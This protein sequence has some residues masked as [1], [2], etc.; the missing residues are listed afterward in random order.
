LFD[1]G[2]STTSIIEF[3]I[4]IEVQSLPSLEHN[5]PLSDVVLFLSLFLLRRR[6]I[7]MAMIVAMMRR[8]PIIAIKTIAHK[9]ND[10]LE[11]IYLKLIMNSS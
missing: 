1:I 4:G 10:K 2:I 6:N 7:I 5:I 11:T 9:G 3:V 8:E